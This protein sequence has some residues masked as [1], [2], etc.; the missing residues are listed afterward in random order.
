MGASPFGPDARRSFN[1]PL[2]PVKLMSK[3]WE[4]CFFSKFPYYLDF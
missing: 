2:V 3:S 1:R 4:P